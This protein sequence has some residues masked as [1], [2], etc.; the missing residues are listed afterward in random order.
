MRGVEKGVEFPIRATDQFSGQ[1]DKLTQK[2]G[3]AVGGFD[4][5]QGLITAVTAGGLT[6]ATAA[7]LRA[8]DDAMQSA[9]KLE[10]V[11]RATGNATGYTTNQLHALADALART[12]RFDDEA[13]RD[14]TATLV[15]FGNIGGTNLERVLKLAADY[16]AVTG[17]ELTTAA[18]TLARALNDPA[19]GISRLE[20]GFGDLGKETVAAIKLQE[21]MGNRSGAL[22]IALDALEKK[23]GGSD[24]AMNQGLTA[25]VR[26]L[27]KAVSELMETIGSI[28]NN[29]AVTGFIDG[30]AASLRG[31]KTVMEGDWTLKFAA[32]VAAMGGR[33][34]EHL[35]QLG[36]LAVGTPIPGAAGSGPFSLDDQDARARKILEG[37]VERNKRA[38]DEIAAYNQRMR[39]LH[40]RGEDDAL[41][42]EHAMLEQAMADKAKL[43][44]ASFAAG[45][46]IRRMELEGQQWL[47]NNVQRIVAEETAQVAKMREHNLLGIWDE[48]STRAGD[49]FEDLIENGRDAFRNLGDTIKDFG[50]QL[51]GLF[52]R[53]WILS[54]GASLTG[55]AALGAQASQLGGGTLAGGLLDGFGM[56]SGLGALLPGGSLG[57]AFG[58]VAQ[59]GAGMLGLSGSVGSMIGSVASFLPGIGAAFAVAAALY[60]A[61]NDGPENPNLRIF[62]GAGGAGLFG[63]IRTEGNYSWD[64]TGL[65]SYI[66]GLDQRFAAIL[67][68][69][70]TAN[71]SAALSRYTGTGLRMDGQPAQFAFPEGDATAGEQLAMELLQSRYGI[72]FDEID[73]EIAN[74]IRSWGG[75]SGELQTYIETMLSVVEGLGKLNL[76]GLNVES[77]RALGVAGESLEQTFQRVASTWSWFTQNFYTEAE[78]LDMAT[79]EV[80]DVFDAL[81]IAVPSSVTDFRRLVEGLDLSTESGRS[82]WNMLMGVAPAF[83]AVTNAADGAT[84]STEDLTDALEEQAELQRRIADDVRE[85]RL[86]Q[87]DNVI[88]ARAGLQRFLGTTALNSQLTVLTPQERLAEAQRQ[89]E[90][91]LNLA[92]AGDLNAAGR[93]G[94]AAETYLG[95]ARELF[96]SASRYVDI[97]N[98]VT[99]DVR[100]V[101]DRLAID[102]RIL[103]A[104]LGMAATMEQ[105]RDILLDIRDKPP[106]TVAAG[107]KHFAR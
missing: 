40:L 91:I 5:L 102:Q 71:A 100:G 7:M 29:P 69:Q 53:R 47:S 85:S 24:Q 33:G 3:G 26:G 75:S 18:E 19:E 50:R 84:S 65:N 93:L 66:S 101:D 6:A 8:A 44:L 56:A 88:N 12:S 63:G 55:S 68:P 61:F 49:F 37:L 83:L 90:E 25:S 92:R 41:R 11:L 103:E 97:F 32:V 16:A 62:Q 70:G 45:E 94:G 17:G 59:M 57:T 54:L 15:R 89:Y 95:I 107:T 96:G 76:R 81:G 48:L 31:L 30:I 99:G 42:A 64:M 1:F 60:R 80:N 67:G 36:N 28:G 46:E 51:V 72:L 14:A 22:A 105:V 39:E 82:M 34:F 20:R 21:E 87:L 77:L 106:P 74:T 58:N 10:A 13:F 27:R 73:D 35:M 78:R 2:L 98:A 86:R 79:Q 38:A 23:I 9:L 52:A 4:R 43:R 104:T